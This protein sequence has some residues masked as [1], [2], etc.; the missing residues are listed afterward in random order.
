MCSQI[1]GALNLYL[2][3]WLRNVYKS[4]GTQ[5]VRFGPRHRAGQICEKSPLLYLWVAMYHFQ[6]FLPPR[7]LVWN[8]SVR[9]DTLFGPDP[10]P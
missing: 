9:M 1:V 5:I 6:G 2:V 7:S 3:P 10:P 8:H 4:V